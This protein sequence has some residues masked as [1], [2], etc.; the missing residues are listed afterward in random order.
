MLAR[1]V[2]P[3]NLFEELLHLGEAFS[4]FPLLAPEARAVRRFSSSPS[5][6]RFGWRQVVCK[7]D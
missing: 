5:S 6:R 2:D 3:S 4:A 7:E 1:R